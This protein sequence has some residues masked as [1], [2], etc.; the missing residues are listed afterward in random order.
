MDHAI[1]AGI[2]LPASR[3]GLGTRPMRGVRW[4]GPAE[5]MSVRI[6]ASVLVFADEVLE[7]SMA[8]PVSSECMAPA[9]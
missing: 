3:I 4:G 6:D 8:D 2:D 7:K 5:V 1:V 9:A